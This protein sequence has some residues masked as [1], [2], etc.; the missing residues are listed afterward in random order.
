M[1]AERGVRGEVGFIAPVEGLRGVAVL[2][3]MVFHYALVLDARFADPWIAAS[4]AWLAAKVV[5]RNGMLGVDLFFLI[6]G[7]LLVLPWLRH[8]ADGGAAPS[9]TAFYRR[10]V[11]RILPAY[12]VH[13]LILFLVLVPLLRGLEFWRYDPAHLF[14]NLSAHVFLVHYLSP[15][16][17]ASVG[18]NGALWTLSLEAQFYLLLPLLAP[19]FARAPWRT[20]LALLATALAWRWAAGHGLDAL[21]ASLQ[22][23]VPTQV[24]EQTMRHFLQTQL[25]GYLGHF[26]AGMLAARAWLQWRD[27]PPSR[28][29]S[30]A[31][32]ALAACAGLLL[33]SLHAPG[34]WLL[35]DL[36]WALVLAALATILVALVARGV[37]AAR[38]LLANRPLLFVGRVSYS[39]YLYH[40]PV[41]LLWNLYAPAVSGSWVVFP[42]YVATVL[43][44]AWLS[45]RYVEVPGMASA[46]A[47]P[48]E[49]PPRWPEPEAQPRPTGPA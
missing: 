30:I 27:H 40:L 17:S 14:T 1:D 44:I 6:T 3:V 23:Q 49:A 48:R 32:L 28:A 13:L 16:T 39:A 20:A 25:P 33:W 22:A 37:A 4:E 43:A 36:T 47:S 26:A 46:S 18:V 8:A 7:F 35:G 12:Y 15:V 24:S 11:R 45:Y 38:S 2:L 29:A 21:V 9:A 10:R 5:V 34:G 31:W 42:S 41:I 19:A